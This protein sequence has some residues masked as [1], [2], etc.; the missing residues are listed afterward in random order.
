MSYANTRDALKRYNEMAI[1]ARVTAAGPHELIQMLFDGALEKIAAAKGCML[2]NQPA[3]KGTALGRAIAIIDY[4]NAC[5]D[6]DA[7][8]ELVDN[9]G[10]LYGYM[11]R[12]LL[13]A[14]AQNDP[15]PLDEVAG[16][17]R[18]IKIGW[19]AIP[20]DIRNSARA[21]HKAI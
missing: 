2:R 19:D 3:E 4:L 9:L 14:H 20:Q 12:R 6:R 13:Q 18:E 21:A 1:Q 5:L 16:L 8:G 10:A 17:L 7:G 15:G 11:T